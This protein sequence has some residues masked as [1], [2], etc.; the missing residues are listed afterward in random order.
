MKAW[1]R[2]ESTRGGLLSFS[3]FLSMT[4]ASW[5]SGIAAQLNSNTATATLSGSFAESLT[6]TVTSGSTV[7]F[8]LA[9]GSTADGDVPVSIETTWSL[10]LLRTNVSLY[11]Y[12][13]TPSAALTD[14]SGNDIPSSA[15]FGQMTTGLPTSYTA[16]SQTNALGPAGGGLHLFSETILVLN[17]NKTRNDN[18][19]L[20]IDLT[21]LTSLPPATYAGTLR[22]Q[23][24]AL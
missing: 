13:S 7:T 16:F 14:G 18:L 12:F 3:V 15:V 1:K 2:R 5:P 6:V 23:A 22:I 9:P 24:Q 10:N 11:A 20:R 21:S 17:R 19:N 8:P 4:V